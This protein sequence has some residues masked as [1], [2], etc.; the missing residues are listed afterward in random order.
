MSTVDTLRVDL[1]ERSYDIVIGE[2]LLPAAGELLAPVLRQPRCFVVTDETVAGLHL[3]ALERAL[4]DASIEAHSIVLP[5]GEATKDFAHLEWLIDRL[6][7]LG[8]ERRSALIALGG[9]VIGDLTGFAASIA[10]RGVDFVQVP[11][12][13]L[14][15]VD[16]SV[17]GKTGINMKAGKNLVGSFHQP[18][19]V[20]ADSDVLGT[21]TRR[22]MMAGYAEILKYALIG[23]RDFFEWLEGHG[24]DIVEGQPGPLR[25]AVLTSCRAKAAVVAADEREG[26]QRGLLNLGHTFGHALEAECG[27]GTDLLHGEAVAIG[28]VLAFDL[29]VELGLCPAE[30]ADRVRHHIAAVG[31]PTGPA[32][33]AGR[34]WSIESLM[35][36]MSRDKKVR[37]GR[38]TFVLTRGIGRAFLTDDVSL[39]DVQLLLQG[40][41]AA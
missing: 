21:L 2:A 31:L 27:Y 26:G 10:L 12:T 39:D 4:T 18:R 38:I 30:D 11:T 24:S 35:Q 32:S 7:D 28:M 5:A 40:A 8:I 20:L 16:S 37:D 22:E 41:V 29:S 34:I 33:V 19:R 23:D 36:H 13:L 14:A 3:A 9:G 25:R 6:L 17:G 1:G 15:Q